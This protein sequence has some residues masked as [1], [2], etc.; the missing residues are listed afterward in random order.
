MGQPHRDE[1]EQLQVDI[2]TL[3]RRLVMTADL[4]EMS[5]L[6]AE[7]QALEEYCADIQ[8]RGAKAFGVVA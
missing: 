3:H 8:S 4:K 2:R 6:L 5:R 1:L 7:I